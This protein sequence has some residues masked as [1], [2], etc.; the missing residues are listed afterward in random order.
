MTGLAYILSVNDGQ[1]TEDFLCVHAD[2]EFHRF[3]I[4]EDTLKRLAAETAHRLWSDKAFY[5]TG[6]K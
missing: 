3:Q 1:K 4:G 2:G 6:R 5:A